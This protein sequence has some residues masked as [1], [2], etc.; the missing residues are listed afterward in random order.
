[1]TRSLI[2]LSKSYPQRKEPANLSQQKS[3]LD[4]SRIIIITNV[5]YVHKARKFGLQYP[6]PSDLFVWF[7]HADM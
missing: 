4:F 5:T 6:A 7:Y 3:Q 1:M 2:L